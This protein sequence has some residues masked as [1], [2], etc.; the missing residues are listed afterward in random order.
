MQVKSFSKSHLSFHLPYLLQMQKDGWGQLWERDIKEVFREIFPIKDYTNHQFSLDF[1][2]LRLDKS[3]YKDGF[4]A[5]ENDDSFESPMRV[6]FALKNLKSGEIKEQEVFLTDFPLMT[7]NGTFIINGVERVVI[8][9]LI[10]SS[11]VFFTLRIFQGRN[12]FGAKVI[13]VRGAWLEFETDT[14]GFIG[15]KINRQRKVAATTLLRAFGLADTEKIKKEFK[16]I[17]KGE[18]KYIEKTLARDSATTQSEAFVEIYK[19]L[20]PGDLVSPDAAKELVQNMF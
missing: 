20:R 11:G 1:V 17:D 8:P 16:D 3:K 18:I 4:S 19:K 6:K 2:D 12:Y 13:P 5:K 15:V 7:E 10:R 9:Q 14:S